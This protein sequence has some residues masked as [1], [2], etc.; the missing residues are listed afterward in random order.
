M[1]KWGNT[2]SGARLFELK[3]WF[4]HVLAVWTLANYFT[5]LCLKSSYVKWGDKQDNLTDL[6]WG[7]DEILYE[8][9]S[10]RAQ[11][12]RSTQQMPAVTTLVIIIA[13]IIVQKEVLILVRIKEMK[14][15][16]KTPFLC[17]SHW[18]E[19]K[20]VNRTY[21]W[22]GMEEQVLQQTLAGLRM[23]SSFWRVILWRSLKMLK[24]HVYPLIQILL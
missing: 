13:I 17:Q 3:P 9:C 21:D 1:W 2:D 23:D 14:I 19:K 18:Q 10:G 4:G 5:S 7:L 24:K 16:T 11:H 6:F 12:M 22:Q 8:R 20:P 15:G